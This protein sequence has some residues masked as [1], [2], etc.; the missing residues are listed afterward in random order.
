MVILVLGGTRFV[1]RDLVKLLTSN[2]KNEV[3]VISRNTNEKT[4]GVNYISLDRNNNS[5]L[6]K[7]LYEIKPDIII[8][9][10]CF[11]SEHTEP[12]KLYNENFNKLKHY[13]M[14]STFFV[15]LYDKSINKEKQIISKDI[16]DNY[17]KNKLTAENEIFEDKL[18]LKATL[19]RF[20]FIVSYDDYTLR[21]RNYVSEVIE[22]KTRLVSKTKKSFITKKSAVE[23]INSLI[24][25]NPYGFLDLSNKGCIT[26]SE[27]SDLI[28]DYFNIEIKK[29]KEDTIYFVSDDICLDSRKITLNNLKQE[30]FDE[31]YL[32]KEYMSEKN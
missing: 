17:A 7:H 20:P 12:I 18:F 6:Y 24:D 23:A 22:R 30:L 15:Y 28:A 10:I 11:S 2:N 3:F 26:S 19:I 9:F 1:G 13:I 29:E 5:L 14:I 31:L 32:I 16:N 4:K 8:D 27:L 25:S 21:F